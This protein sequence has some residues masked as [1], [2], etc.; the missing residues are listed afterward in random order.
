MRGEMV[1][2]LMVAVGVGVNGLVYWEV[3]KLERKIERMLT[4]GKFEREL[5]T[6]LVKIK[7][8]G[9]EKMTKYDL[10]QKLSKKTGVPVGQVLKI[11]TN[12]G[13]AIAEGLLE[14][15]NCINPTL[16]IPGFGRFQIKEDKR[17][18]SG[19]KLTFKPSIINAEGVRL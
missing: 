9:E 14:Q 2:A 3:V 19:K 11:L 8:G 10:A 13:E 6:T 5:P 7:T 17:S 4:N 1:I 15:K 18:K 12:L 16:T